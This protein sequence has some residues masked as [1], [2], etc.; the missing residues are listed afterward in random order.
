MKT[1][2]DNDFTVVQP[3]MKGKV[4]TKTRMSFC[5]RCEMVNDVRGNFKSE[6]MRNGDEAALL[7]DN[8]D[9]KQIE[10]QSH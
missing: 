7:F 1:H 2:K 10:T 5:V 9:Q 8:C 4:L 6:Y 3:Y